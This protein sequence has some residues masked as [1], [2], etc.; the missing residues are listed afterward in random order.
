M[1][2]YIGLACYVMTSFAFSLFEAGV[3]LSLELQRGL[4]LL[5]QNAR[6]MLMDS[7][8]FS[9]LFFNYQKVLVQIYPLILQNS[10]FLTVLKL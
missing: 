1:S 3:L 6:A 7:Q 8:R 5:S 4:Y 10:K 9:F 2:Y